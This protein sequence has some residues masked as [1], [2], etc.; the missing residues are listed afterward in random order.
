MGN[1]LG[2]FVMLALCVRLALPAGVRLRAAR[3]ARWIA[4]AALL[5]A[6]QVA[7]G[8][9]VSASLCRPEL[10]RLERLRSARC[11]CRR[12]AGAA[13]TRGAS[14]CSAA[15]PPVNPAG[16][17]ANSLHRHAGLLLVLLLLPLAWLALR[18][19]RRRSAAR[20]CSCCSPRSSRSGWR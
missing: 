6:A 18:R 19:G 5:L 15:T 2:G 17:L 11:R 8:G 13:W 7:L 4:A 12:R 3:C 9:L 20:C 10:Q 16:A 14:R 1:L